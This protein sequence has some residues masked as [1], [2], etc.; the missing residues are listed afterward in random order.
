[1]SNIAFCHFRVGLTDG[2]SLEIDKWKKALEEMGHRVF[3]I[4]G[5]APG[6]NATIIPELYLGCSLIRIIYKNA[7][8]SLKDFASEEEFS[9][10]I[11]KIAEFIEDR[12]SSFI[13]KYEIDILVVENIW[14]LPLNIPAAI[15]IYKVI[16][17]H[18]IKTIAHHHDFFWE[19]HYYGNPTCSLIKQ[20]LSTYF[21]PDN[22]LINHVVINSI[23]RN[24]LKRRRKIQSQV[25]PNIF[26]FEASNW[27]MDDYNFDLKEKIGLRSNDIVVL[28]AT[29]II[30]RKGIGL[31]ID[32]VKELSKSQNLILIKRRG[33]YKK[34]K[35]NEKSRVVLV[36]PN[37]IEN[38]EY[39]KSLREKIKKEG[40]DVLF[41]S[42]IIDRNRKIQ[43]HSKSYSLWDT[44]LLADLVT[45][46][47][48]YEG[49]G[50]QFLEAINAKLPIVIYEY[51]VFT[52]DIKQKGFKVISLGSKIKGRDIRGLYYIDPSTIKKAAEESLRMLTDFSYR[53]KVTEFNY[54]LGVKHYSMHALKNYL[55]L[56]M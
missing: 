14:A 32:L 7:F 44:Y 34:R 51:K 23:A 56:I 9:S 11:N 2:V 27:K 25:I 18:K 10:E 5:E 48:F 26:D 46:P 28:Q 31:A 21:P 33:F 43:N 52:E 41:I 30:P 40:I 24:E 38:L 49:W 35:I 45:Y 39:F 37:L 50:N 42:D 47:S 36:F 19:R 16:K 1:M 12:M 55:R 6:I 15:A 53:K 8:Y 13:K 22:R 17:L 29:R 4:A 20:L 3:L 54:S